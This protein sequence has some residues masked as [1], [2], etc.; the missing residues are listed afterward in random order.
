MKMHSARAAGIALLAASGG[1]AGAAP[2][3]V[4]LW[5]ELRW[6]EAGAS[7]A[8]LQAAA[9]G[10]VVVGTAGSVGPAG[11]PA[12]VT[13][14]RP[15]AGG[16]LEA[17]PR[18]LVRNG[19]RAVWQWT[20]AAPLQWAPAAVTLQGA[21]APALLAAPSALP[22]QPASGFEITP[23]WPGGAQPVQVEL[24]A[25][26]GGPERG[27]ATRVQTA[28]SL[29]LQAW[30]TVAVSPMPAGAVATEQRSRELQLRV[31]VA[32]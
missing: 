1:A 19:Q 16:R 2:P 26:Q 14:T 22:A 8:S 18:L 28:V 13:S 5:V 21:A 27:G 31:S 15:D 17:L 11:R 25:S 3:D 12:Q 6:V 32:P 23:R 30:R 20:Q 4:N 9:D 10:A 29:P 7:P 24:Q